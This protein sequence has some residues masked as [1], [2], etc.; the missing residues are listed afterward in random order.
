MHRFILH[1]EDLREASARVLSPGQVGL[2]SG[3][4]VFST[5]R[6][7][8][9]VL[10]AWERHW[11]RMK[12]DATLLRIPFPSDS[13]VVQQRLLTLA[14]ANGAI[15]GTMRVAVVRNKGGLWQGPDIERDYDLIA[16]TTSPS[17]WGE[18][19]RLAVAP[20][21]RHA[22]SMF[23]GTKVLAW[24]HNLA[25]LE[26]AQSRGFDEVILLNER[27][28]VSECT[29]A[30]IFVVEGS[31][32]WTPP[33]RSGCL[34]GVTR[35]ILLSEVRPPGLAL[36]EKDLRLRDLQR[37][38]EVLITST[39]RN[40]LPVLSIEGIPLRHGGP[41]GRALQSAFASYVRDFIL[42]HKEAP[43]VAGDT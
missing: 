14:R 21:A 35:E 13:S 40:L 42:R 10:F 31:R 33:L 6:I 15:D 4:G 11:A 12:R 41:V 1:N 34:P 39:T 20:Q 38:D 7:A 5:I 16:F 32:V 28:D 30:N 8:G 23:A 29:S 27:G 9:G 22:A 25:L 37:A 18:G 36:G 24:G 43:V 3:W 26:D 2:L 17:N 19:A